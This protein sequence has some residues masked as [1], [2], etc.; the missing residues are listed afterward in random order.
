MQLSKVTSV[1]PLGPST[2]M[3][4]SSVKVAQ[5]SISV[6]LFFFIRKW[7]P[8]AIRSATVRLRLYATPKSKLTS[9]LIPNVFASWVK[10]CAISALRSSD[11][12]GMQPTLLHT[13]PQYLS[14]MMAVFRPSWAARTAAT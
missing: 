9:P 6:T 13:P 10:M 7:T 12:V 8:L 4:L 1:V 14:S 11:F 3:V 5:P 2:L